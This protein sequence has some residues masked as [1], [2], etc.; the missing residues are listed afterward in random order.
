MCGKTYDATSQ[1]VQSEWCYRRS[2]VLGAERNAQGAI[3]VALILQQLD[4]NLGGMSHQYTVS[5]ELEA[6]KGQ[7]FPF[8][9]VDFAWLIPRPFSEKTIIVIGE[10]KDQG[11]GSRTNGGGTINE[12]DIAKLR[13]VADSFP[14]DR[15]EVYIVLAKLCDFTQKE[16]ELA[17]SLNDQSIQRVILFTDR[18]LEPFRFYERTE[19]VLKVD[20]YGGSFRTLASATVSIFFTS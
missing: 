13:S 12:D 15:F 11:R 4:A 17:K 8:C 16:I 14:V 19:K 2:G 18:Q 9:E 3:P 6:T 7:V 1:L 5:L 10:C 20:Q